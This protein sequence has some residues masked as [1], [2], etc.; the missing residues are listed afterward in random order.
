M[1]LSQ[2]YLFY[3]VNLCVYSYT[4]TTVFTVATQQDLPWGTRILPTAFFFQI[5]LAVPGLSLSYVFLNKL[6][7]IYK[8][9]K[10]TLL[11]F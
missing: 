7:H 11:R 9:K 8:K 1:N 10:K 6:I 3:S 5:V 2:N 4:S